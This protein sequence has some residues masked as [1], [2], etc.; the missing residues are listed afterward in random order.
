MT[1]RVE[2][3]ILYHG[4]DA[5]DYFPGAGVAFSR[6]D[7]IVTGIGESARQAA[8]DAFDQMEDG[9]AYWPTADDTAALEQA[10][11]DLSDEELERTYDACEDVDCDGCEG[12]NS[13]WH[14]YVSIRW[15]AL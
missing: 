3:E 9:L 12:C 4:C 15:R 13:E 5:E 10:I 6:Y 2:F 1:R 11:E 8:W 14:H 7:H